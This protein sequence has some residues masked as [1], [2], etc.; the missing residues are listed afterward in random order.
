MC[1][2]LAAIFQPSPSIAVSFLILPGDS[3]IMSFICALLKPL[4]PALPA[5]VRQVTPPQ[6]WP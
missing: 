4:C 5:S 3:M 2:T 6:D 1:P